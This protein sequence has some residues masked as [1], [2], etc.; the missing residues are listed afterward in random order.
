MNANDLLLA[1]GVIGTGLVAGL[2]YGWAVS[3]IPGTTRVGDHTYVETMQDINRAIINPAFIVPFMGMPLALGAASVLH[4]R[5]GDVRR[6]WLL[7]G[8]TGTYL[9][10]VLGVTVRG[11]IPLNDALDAFDLPAAA[12]DDLSERRR[13]YERPWNR[14]HHLRTAAGVVSFGLAAAAAMV[15]AD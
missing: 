7:A 5:S 12:G 15:A 14:L 10:G 6:G 2:L 8:A 13:T 1:T 4:F 3:V 11:N 9:V